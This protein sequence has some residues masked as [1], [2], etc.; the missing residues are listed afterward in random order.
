MHILAGGGTDGRS[1][2]IVLHSTVPGGNNSAGVAWSA[3]VIG[4]GKNVS[5]MKSGT[6]PGQ[7]DPTELAQI[8]AGT[9]IEVV[10]I[11]QDDP[12]WTNPQRTAD[13]DLR[14]QQM[15]DEGTARIQ[16]ALKF[17]GFTRG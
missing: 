4:A 16:A 5:I 15:L 8:Q 13:L 14:S 11:W 9:T 6:D 7:I 1:Y 12:T 3:A 17:F 10:G 2:S